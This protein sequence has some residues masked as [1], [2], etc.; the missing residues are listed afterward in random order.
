MLANPEKVSQILTDSQQSIGCQ[1]N[2]EYLVKG[3][4]ITELQD[5]LI[6]ASGKIDSEPENPLV[7]FC[8]DNIP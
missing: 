7:L 4:N 5:R 1:V 3:K 8:K 6:S 2:P